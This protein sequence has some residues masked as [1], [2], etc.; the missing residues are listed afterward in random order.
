MEIWRRYFDIFNA[1]PLE[2]HTAAFFPDVP[3][4]HDFGTHPS[5]FLRPA[6]A[7][8]VEML[9]QRRPPPIFQQLLFLLVSPPRETQAASDAFFN[10]S[11]EEVEDLML[12]RLGRPTKGHPAASQSLF[13]DD[14][15]STNVGDGEL[16]SANV[17]H[18]GE[19]FAAARTFGWG[20]TCLSLG[21][22]PH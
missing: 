10:L 18:Q 13:D 20:G 5:L 11:G 15:M 19:D 4:S 9:S 7:S 21:T 17:G 22:T 6:S 1:R 16:E 8:V 12:G 14:D 2:D 3:T